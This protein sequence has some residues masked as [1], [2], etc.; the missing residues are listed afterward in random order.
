LAPLLAP[1]RK[2]KMV[3]YAAYGVA[4]ENKRSPGYPGLVP[5]SVQGGSAHVET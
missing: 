4:H 3:P 5:S 2:A 1:G